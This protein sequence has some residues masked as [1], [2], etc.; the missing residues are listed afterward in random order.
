MTTESVIKKELKE[1]VS[2]LELL[3]QNPNLNLQNEDLL[4][5]FILSV[6]EEEQQ[7]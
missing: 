3:L 1:E 2:R 7:S 6:I 5:L 4:S